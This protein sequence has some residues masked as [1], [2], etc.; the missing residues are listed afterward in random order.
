MQRT[1][2]LDALLTELHILVTLWN[3]QCLF[4]V[5]NPDV[6][7]SQICWRGNQTELTALLQ[8]REIRTVERVCV[9]LEQ[10]GRLHRH[11]ENPREPYLY[12]VELSAIWDAL[13]E[14]TLRVSRVEIN[15]YPDDG[16]LFIQLVEPDGVHVLGDLR[17][18]I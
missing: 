4:A 7:F 12:Q 3:V 10:Q 6:V 15:Q 14:L 2:R 5:H 8:K 18:K 16:M 11:R 1:E 13:T 17:E 9:R